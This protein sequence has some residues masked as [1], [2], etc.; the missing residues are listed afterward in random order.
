MCLTTAARPPGYTPFEHRD[1]PLLTTGRSNFLDDL[2]HAPISCFRDL[3][4]RQRVSIVGI[5][6]AEIS[7]QSGGGQGTR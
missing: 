4:V 3:H 6:A 5:E 7:T 2:R 1:Q